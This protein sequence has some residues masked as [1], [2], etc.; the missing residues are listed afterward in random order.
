MDQSV[1]EHEHVCVYV[2]APISCRASQRTINASVKPLASRGGMRTSSRQSFKNTKLDCWALHLGSST[3]RLRVRRTRRGDKCRPSV[4]L[5]F[6]NYCD[7][8]VA[9]DA[10]LWH[11]HCL[12]VQCDGHLIQAPRP[13]DVPAKCVCVCVCALQCSDLRP[14]GWLAAPTGRRSGKGRENAHL[15]CKLSQPAQLTRLGHAPSNRK[16]VCAL[17][18][19]GRRRR[20]CC[21]WCCCFPCCCCCCSWCCSCCFCS[22]RCTCGCP[23]QQT[24]ARS[25]G[26]HQR[27][28][29]VRCCK[30]WL[31]NIKIARL[32]DAR[33]SSH[34]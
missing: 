33:P 19:S 24:Q 6:W 27:S 29:G 32:Q 11:A 1:D 20:R 34:M 21:W 25:T 30:Q 4:K 2:S 31:K 17:Q 18:C 8:N 26:D 14:R 15:R 16:P 10:E 9:A 28:T 7:S 23:C 3:E 22:G 13:A 5:D 12:D